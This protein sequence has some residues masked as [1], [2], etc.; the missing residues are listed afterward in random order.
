MCQY[1]TK[2]L[3]CL[4]FFAQKNVFQYNQNVIM[5]IIKAINQ[6]Y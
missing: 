2:Y 6:H 4:T 1:K 5:R 3:G